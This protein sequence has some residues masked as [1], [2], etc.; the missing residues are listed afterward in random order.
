[1]PLLDNET[2][3]HPRIESGE[4]EVG[5]RI[6]DVRALARLTAAVHACIEIRTGIG[7]DIRLKA[8]LSREVLVG[9]E[10]VLTEEVILTEQVVLGDLLIDSRLEAVIGGE[11][12]VSEEIVITEEVVLTEQVVL[13]E[14]ILVGKITGVTVEFVAEFIGELLIEITKI[15]R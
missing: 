4:V 10:V 3:V 11:V 7:V 2:G 6:G 15:V 12:V 8:V 1:M 14:Q 13:G 5:R 9:Q